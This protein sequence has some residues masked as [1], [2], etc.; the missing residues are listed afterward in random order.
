MPCTFCGVKTEQHRKVCDACR[1]R[2]NE[3]VVTPLLR[4]PNKSERDIAHLFE[5]QAYD[6]A[7]RKC[8]EL[9]ARKPDNAFA[10]E[11][12]GDIAY[13]QSRFREAIDAYRLAIQHNDGD[14]AEVRG[15]LDQAI[16]ALREDGD[17][18]EENNDLSTVEL[19]LA[20]AEA[21]VQSSE[22]G[23]APAEA[24]SPHLAPADSA[25]PISGPL[26]ASIIALFQPPDV[27]GAITTPALPKLSPAVPSSALLPIANS[28]I[29]ESTDVAV[30]TVES[31]APE[32]VPVLIISGQPAEA[33]ERE[34]ET[35]A[36]APLLPWLTP[37]LVRNMLRVAAV[38]VILLSIMLLCHPWVHR[39]VA[40]PRVIPIPLDGG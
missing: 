13:A 6:A 32:P 33:G 26:P 40:P 35:T 23:E 24:P 11:V 38:L 16:D 9:L 18:C 22:A 8:A 21:I 25:V 7:L 30:A 17:L 2:L 36:E 15:K 31:P 19:L 4:E 34:R 27:S 12:S 14:T 3:R 28:A 37:A 5:Q 20:S 29:D 10:H 39:Y 1:D